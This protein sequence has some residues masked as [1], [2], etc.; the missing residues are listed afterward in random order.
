MQATATAYKHLEM[1]EH[2]CRKARNLGERAWLAEGDGWIWLIILPW[3]PSVS[4]SL[5]TEKINV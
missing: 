3:E 2:M 1:A 5:L 4:G